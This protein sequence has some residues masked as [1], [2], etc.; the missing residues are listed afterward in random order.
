VNA[1]DLIKYVTDNSY[2]CTTIIIGRNHHVGS[3]Q[4]QPLK[5]RR[6]IDLSLPPSFLQHPYYVK[7]E[8]N[9]TTTKIIIGT[10]PIDPP[11]IDAYKSKRAFNGESDT[12]LLAPDNERRD[13]P[14]APP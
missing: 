8:M 11:L 9:V 10:S 13:S 1:Q 3:L 5:K 7:E 4:D 6:I 12:C 14:I 2:Q